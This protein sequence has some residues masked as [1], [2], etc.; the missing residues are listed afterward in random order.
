MVATVSFAFTKLNNGAHS[1]D[2]DPRKIYKEKCSGCHGERVD[3]FVDRQWKHGKS[4]EELIASINSGYAEFGM[5]TWKDVLTP[6]EIE[7][8]AD[9][10][11]E[12]LKTVE[13]YLSLIHI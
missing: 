3:A 6:K 1:A 13:Q 4:R 7:G 12:S 8:M 5:P 10:I 2:T 9:L 11:T